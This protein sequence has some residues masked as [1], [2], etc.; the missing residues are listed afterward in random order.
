MYALLAENAQDAR[1][2]AEQDPLHADGI[3]R[4]EMLPWVQQTSWE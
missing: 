2:L 1:A 4:F 3:R